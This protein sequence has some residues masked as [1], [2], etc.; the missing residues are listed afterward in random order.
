[1]NSYLSKISMCAY[2]WKMS[3]NPNIPKQSQELTFCKKQKTSP[4]ICNHIFQNKC[5]SDK[6]I[7]D[8][9]LKQKSNIL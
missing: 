6:Q 1:M 4:L 9:P 3:F 5:E 2:Q 8:K 7:Q